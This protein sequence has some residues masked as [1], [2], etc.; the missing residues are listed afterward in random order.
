[1]NGSQVLQLI[2]KIAASPGK[3]DKQ[4][5]VNEGM[6]SPL[7]K[8][9]CEYAYS[10]FKTYGLRQI[11]DRASHGVEAMF[12]TSTWVILD[13]LI[14]RELTGTAARRAVED[15]LNRLD[16]DSAE[17][18][19]RMI[20]KDLRAGFSESTINKACKGLIP[21]FPYQRCSLPKDA[22]LETWPW[23]EGAISQEKA[24]GMFA[25]VDHEE[26]GLVSIR[27]RQGSEFPM[28]KFADIAEDIRNRTTPGNQHHGEFVVVK[29]GKVCRRE[30]GNGIMNHVLAGGDFAP[31]E[32]PLYMIWD[33]IPLSSVVSKGKCNIPYKMRLG[34]LIKQL[35]TVPG[36]A[37]T[38]I[39]TRIVK[40]LQ[41]A[42]AHAAELMKDGK[43]GSVVKNPHGIWKD[44][45]SKDQVKL[46]LEFEVDLKITAIVPGRAGTKNEGRAGSMTCTTSDNKL[47]TDVTVKNEA[48]RDKVDAN[49]EDWIGRVITVVA[50]DIMP[51]GDSSAVHALFLPRMVEA[52]YRTDKTEADSLQRVFDQKEAAIL[53][54]KIMKEAA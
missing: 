35:K 10:P 40:S 47:F 22:K 7:F 31:D 43:E 29:G 48:M 20:R 49:P 8:Q 33:Q 13:G 6:N 32:K 26:G 2:D 52:A 42:Y 34:N 23:E 27:S 5:L 39:P 50:N 38:L 1:M 41:D 17:L 25:N 46:K 30:I 4:A 45:T 51:P 14:S 36:T 19:T 37:I 16:D 11:P 53:G 24:D 9:V 3:L 21:E 44:G 12:D 28:D 18:F 54:E 15:E